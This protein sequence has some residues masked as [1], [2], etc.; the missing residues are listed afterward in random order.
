M[1]ISKLLLACQKH[2]TTHDQYFEEVDKALLRCE[3]VGKHHTDSEKQDMIFQ[4]FPHQSESQWR[5]K[6]EIWDDRRPDSYESLKEKIFAQETQFELRRSEGR[7]SSI[8]AAAAYFLHENDTASTYYS[9]D[10]GKASKGGKGGKGNCGK[11][12]K[13][14]GGAKGVGKGGTG[15]KYSKGRGRGNANGGRGRGNDAKTY[16]KANEHQKHI[17]CHACGEW[18]HYVRDCPA[19]EWV[20]PVFVTQSSVFDRFDLSHTL[21]SG[22]AAQRSC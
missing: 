17:Q 6:W 14:K 12:F 18:G 5:T 22:L 9:K 3:E 1:A 8:T 7:S 16:K 13:G 4:H 15:G 19:A 11:G 20:M 21:R 2:H 10:G